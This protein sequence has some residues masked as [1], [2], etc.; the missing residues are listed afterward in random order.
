MAYR[1][2]V[3]TRVL[4][5]KKAHS[6]AAVSHHRVPTNLEK[7]DYY[8]KARVFG[9]SLGHDKKTAGQD[10][11]PHLLANGILWVCDKLDENGK[12]KAGYGASH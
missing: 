12:P 8:G 4:H 1:F 3:D 11:Y 6:C 7:S 9:T 5:G 10:V 2:G